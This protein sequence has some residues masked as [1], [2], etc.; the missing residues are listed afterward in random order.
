M[1]QDV[2]Q[3]TFSRHDRQRY[4]ASVERC[5][6]ALEMMLRDHPFARDEP[7]TGVEVELNL[8]GPD[9]E[10]TPMGSAVLRS[11]G[12][13]EFQTELGRWNLELNLPPRPVSICSLSTW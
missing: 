13:A 3:I 11:L 4:R 7:M 6:D 10:P 2:D 8:V 5:L 12:S 9:L 1:G